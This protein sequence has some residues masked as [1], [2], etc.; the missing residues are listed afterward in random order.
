MSQEVVEE[1]EGTDRK[2]S[3]D[4]TLSTDVLYDVLTNRR[5]RYT[6]HYLKQRAGD[7]VEMGD[8]STQV[9][10]WET[11]TDPEALAYDER[12]RVHTS[13]YQHHAP[14]LDD[15]GIVDYDSQRGVIEL[16]E[17]GSD[18]DLYLEA[19]SGRDIPWSTYHLLLSVFGVSLMGAVHLGV[20]PTTLVP[21]VTWGLF[22]AVAFLAS[23]VVFAYDNHV[24]MRLGSDGPPPEVDEEDGAGDDAAA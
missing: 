17:A 12:K 6:I 21:E 5:R 18:L 14:K 8:L 24:S 23:S 22:V 15:A 16:T 11:G 10:A 19:V 9:A 2:Q 13:L 1:M 7:P 4:A 20:P 3:D